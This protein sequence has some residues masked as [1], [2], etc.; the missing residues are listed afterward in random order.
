ML[1]LHQVNAL[2]EHELGVV[3]RLINNGD[4]YLWARVVSLLVPTAELW[5]VDLSAGA[6]A[7]VRLDGRFYDSERLDGCQRWQDLEYVRRA[8]ARRP[9]VVVAPAQP[10]D[11]ARFEAEWYIDGDHALIEGL[12]RDVQRRLRALS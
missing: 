2:F 11:I 5:A 8:E 4:C 10:M 9:L 12:V 6:H 7:F 1:V 3:P